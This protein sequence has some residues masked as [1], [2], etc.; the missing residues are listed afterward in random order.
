MQAGSMAEQHEII[1]LSKSGGTL[2]KFSQ[3]IGQGVMPN[4]IHNKDPAF[5]GRS[6]DEISQGTFNY[7]TA[8]E[9]AIKEGKYTSEALAS[10]HDDARQRVINIAKKSSDTE[11]LTTLSDAARGV[12]ASS[13]LSGK[14]VGVA[15]T[16]IRGL[17]G[18]RTGAGPGPVGT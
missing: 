16:A 10:M 7:E 9:R 8:V 15:K 13:E 1:G 5:A 17:A 6:V 2:S 3:T 11:L 12:E 4:G 18:P 14:V